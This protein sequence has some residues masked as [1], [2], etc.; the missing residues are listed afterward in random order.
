[1]NT[2][3]VWMQFVSSHNSKK[4][5]VDSQTVLHG[6]CHLLKAAKCFSSSLKK[7]LDN[8]NHLESLQILIKS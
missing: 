4:I 7:T 8:Q 2:D 6:E 5:Y 3:L 1:M